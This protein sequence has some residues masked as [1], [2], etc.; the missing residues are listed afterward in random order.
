MSARP[1]NMPTIVGAL[2]WRSS[3]AAMTGSSSQPVELM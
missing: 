2:P 1:V 3:P